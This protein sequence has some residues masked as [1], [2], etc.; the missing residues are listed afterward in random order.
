MQRG[1]NSTDFFKFN[2]CYVPVLFSVTTSRTWLRFTRENLCRA[3]SERHRSAVVRAQC[4]RLIRREALELWTRIQ[5][6]CRMIAIRVANTNDATQKL[7]QHVERVRRGQGGGQSPSYDFDLKFMPPPPKISGDRH[8]VFGF[9]GRPSVQCPIFHVT[10]YL[11]TQWR[12]FNDT[13]HISSCEYKH[14]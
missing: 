5:L 2:K 6:V 4:E 10:R 7:R 1:K 3:Q 9:A 14:C 13:W 11:L 12:Y 8:Y